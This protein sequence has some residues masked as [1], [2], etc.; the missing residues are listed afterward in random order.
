MIQVFFAFYFY[1]HNGFQ[2]KK[3]KLRI[4]DCSDSSAIGAPLAIG[5][6]KPRIE[7]KEAYS[8][9]PYA[10]GVKNTSDVQRSISVY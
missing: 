7:R 8:Y 10:V 4:K 9:F 5:A 6:K 1:K 3:K 2:C